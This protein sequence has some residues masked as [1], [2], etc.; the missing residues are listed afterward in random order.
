M[1]DDFKETFNF[2]DPS[3][4]GEDGLLAYGGNLEPGTL[5]QAYSMGIF[6]W[7]DDSTPIL[8]WSPDPRMI[9]FPDE[10]KVSK[11]LR[12]IINAGKYEC[13]TDTAFES[14]IKKCARVPRKGQKGTWITGEMIEAFL[15]LHHLGFA[16]SVETY[17]GDVL[18]GGLYGVSLGGAF[19]GESMFHTQ[20]DASKFALYCL[21]RKLR[22]WE[23]DFI[24]AQVP[25]DHLQSVGAQAIP[26]DT[27]LEMLR[28][29]LKRSTKKGMWAS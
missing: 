26:R 12:Q 9:L 2:P 7:Y 20:R 8:W 27:F 14:V 18:I 3:L 11:S 15:K 28:T 1:P 29:T 21:V 19:F 23:F 17:E 24:D 22:E 16:H 6:P 4:A 5:L 13:R 10:F 25:T